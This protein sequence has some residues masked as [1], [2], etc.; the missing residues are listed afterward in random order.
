M[1]PYSSWCHRWPSANCHFLCSYYLSLNYLNAN[2]SVRHWVEHFSLATV[3]DDCVR[4]RIV[5]PSTCNNLLRTISRRTFWR[6]HFQRNRIR[7]EWYRRR[8]F[9]SN[10]TSETICVYDLSRVTS[11]PEISF[12][13][14]Y[15]RNEDSN[16]WSA[17]IWRIIR[18]LP[19]C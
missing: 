8:N 2:C 7:S 18:I 14:A 12:K 11:V 1:C 15:C 4:S 10:W 6:T 13:F 19:D 17:R 16:K 3:S 9:Q 5:G